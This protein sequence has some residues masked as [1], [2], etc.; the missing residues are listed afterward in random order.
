MPALIVTYVVLNAAPPLCTRQGTDESVKHMEIL[1]LERLLQGI[2]YEC[3][4][5]SMRITLHTLTLRVFITVYNMCVLLL[6][7]ERM[8]TSWLD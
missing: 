5:H 3:T 4:E 7:S 6:Q 8:E 2:D 1:E